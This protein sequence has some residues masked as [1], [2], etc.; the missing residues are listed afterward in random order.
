MSNGACSEPEP[1]ST[2]EEVIKEPI[3]EKLIT[4]KKSILVWQGHF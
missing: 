1:S 2:N 3:I 4:D